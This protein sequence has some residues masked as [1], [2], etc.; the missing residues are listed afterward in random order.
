MHLAEV[1]FTIEVD[2]TADRELLRQLLAGQQRNTQYLRE[3]LTRMAAVDDALTALI[4]AVD[5]VG[6]EFAQFAEGLP[7][8][9][10][11]RDAALAALAVAQANDATDAQTIADLQAAADAAGVN[12]QTVVDGITTQTARLNALGTPVEPPV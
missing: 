1:K 2:G 5:Q 7:Q 4:A 10:A 8:A 12:L 3:V 6:I 11:D 9:I